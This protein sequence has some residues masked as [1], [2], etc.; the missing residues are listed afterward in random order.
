MSLK[1]YPNTP[2]KIKITSHHLF[3]SSLVSLD[4]RENTDELIEY[5]YDFLLTEALECQSY[6]TKDN[7]I[8]KKFPRIEKI[9]LSYFN[10]I[11]KDIFLYPQDFAIST[12]WV[13]QI[14]SFGC[15]WH[16]HKHCFYSGVYYF[17]SDYPEGSGKLQ[18][19]N[20]L[21][22][23]SDFRLIPQQYSI[24]TTDTW[25]EIPQ[26]N[27]LVLFPSYLEHRVAENKQKGRRSLAFNIVPTGEYGSGDSSYNTSWF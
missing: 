7:R 14:E 5:S 12:S 22:P 19:K 27:K 20:P 1:K 15:Q 17:D 26:K 16:T 9:L 21:I 2:S 4:V 11:A 24:M 10:Q 8:L 18:F 6:M 13:T 25:Q 3:P 23:Y